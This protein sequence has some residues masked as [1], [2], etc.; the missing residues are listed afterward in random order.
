MKKMQGYNRPMTLVVLAGG[1]SRRMGCDKALLPVGART[2]LEET[3]RPLADLFDE[4]L[5][6]VSSGQRIP[7]PAGRAGRVVED[8]I[9]G[10]GPLRGILTG[11][12]AAEHDACFFLACDMPGLSAGVVRKIADQSAAV[13]I[14]IAVTDRSLKEPLLGL[15][16]KSVI[17]E[18]EGLL[19]SGERSILA[20]IDRVRTREV[21][22]R[23]D[24]I[25]LNINTPDEYKTLIERRKP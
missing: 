22:L 9:A 5:I 24:E 2:L 6:V 20:L 10:Q 4:V 16:K 18:I 21:F 7:L 1:Q 25:P 8:E 17:P 23:V 13:E 15:Y 11:L 19:A 12:R 3:I 14:A